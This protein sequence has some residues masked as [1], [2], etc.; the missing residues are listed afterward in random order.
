MSESERLLNACARYVKA[1]TAQLVH[2][3]E[4]G[5]DTTELCNETADAYDAVVAA[6]PI[7]RHP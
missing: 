4:H 1:R 6:S 5:G 3:R 7:G 2:R